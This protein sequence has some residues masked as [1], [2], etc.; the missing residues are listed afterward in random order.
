[1][2]LGVGQGGIY[3]RDGET[4]YK[5]WA[6]VGLGGGARGS[7]VR[8]AGVGAA[9]DTSTTNRRQQWKIFRDGGSHTVTGIC[10]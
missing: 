5:G 4:G 1:M 10:S 2:G 8:R 9:L 7:V 3:R 6:R